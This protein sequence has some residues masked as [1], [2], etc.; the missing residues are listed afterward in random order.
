VKVADLFCGCGGFS[1]GF[2]SVFDF[3]LV[4]ALDNWDV[5]CKSYKANFPYVDVDCRDALEVKPHEIPKVDVIVG[6]P[7]CQEFSILRGHMTKINDPSHIVEKPDVSLVEWFLQVIDKVKPQFW[8]MENVPAVAKYIRSP[9]KKIFRMWNYGV[10]QVRR[11]LFSGIYQTPRK[12][13]TSIIFP[14]VLASEQRGGIVE[15]RHKG[16]LGIRLSSAFRRRAL[17]PEA[18]LVQTFPLDFVVYGSLKDQ[19]TQIGNAVPPLMAY[20]FAEALVNPFQQTLG[21]ES[22]PSPS[23]VGTQ[24]TETEET[25]P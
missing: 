1:L 10:P 4:Y 7:P 5:A 19:Y 23:Q 13:P 17:L 24:E 6:G 14:A 3:E 15:K 25:Q 8:I 12:N 18:K 11:R 22:P 21:V 9:N 20:R 2:E 16:G